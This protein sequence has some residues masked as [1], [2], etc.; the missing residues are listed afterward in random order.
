MGYWDVK[1]KKKEN[2]KQ[3]MWR[4]NYCNSEKV[5]ITVYNSC[6]KFQ[7]VTKFQA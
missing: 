7:A 1:G 6:L 2:G 4:T 3:Q 5:S